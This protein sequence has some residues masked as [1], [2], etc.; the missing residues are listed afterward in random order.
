M[1]LAW[2]EI[3]HAKGK[4]SL[5]ISVV[6]LV[7]YL[8][9]FLTSLAYGLASSY[10][11]GVN[12]WNADN[13]VLTSDSNE[14]IMMSMMTVD[15]LDDVNAT[16]KA[17]LGLFPA[18]VSNP[19]AEVPDGTKAEIY[20]FGI[21]NGSF[22]APNITLADNEVFAD[23]ELQDL[24]Y[25]V[26]SV[27]RVAG[28]DIDWTIVGFGESI[29]YQTAPILYMNLPTWQ[30]YRFAGAVIPVEI[31]SA[32]VTQ[33]ETLSASADIV[34]Y[35]IQDFI[36]NLPGYS[37][38][39]LTFSIMIGFLIFIIAFVLGIFIFVL[40]IQKTAM[41]GVMKAQ[42]ISNAYIGGS[43]V[44]QTLIITGIGVLGG[45]LLTLISGYFLAGIVPFAINPLFYSVITAA[46]F[47]FSAFGGLF[48]VRAV[49]KIDP[50]IAIG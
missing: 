28:T 18:V 49:L 40:T 42:G 10:T 35:S 2:K 20:A 22:I 30:D 12:A 14:N 33:G 3:K 50:R 31:F 37:A 1:F 19:S 25:E 8:V 32:V 16:E 5:I 11:N 13:I 21:D 44:L 48:S 17:R 34:V 27:I 39:V 6:V 23:N 41:F 26:G 9:Y 4:F 24:G 46:F 38:Q 47:V 29:T 43:V 15:D 7:G 36:G 45:L